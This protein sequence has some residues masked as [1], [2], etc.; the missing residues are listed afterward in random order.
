MF[1]VMPL[2]STQHVKALRP[3]PA[4][5]HGV[6]L[7]DATL[8][9]IVAGA[10]LVALAPS[11]AIGIAVVAAIGGIAWMGMRVAAGAPQL[12]IEAHRDAVARA[13]STQI[14]FAR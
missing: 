13:A 9:A 7:V 4:G 14:S 12:L 1:A 11:V 10:V 8:V 3:D 6:S 5:S 2:S